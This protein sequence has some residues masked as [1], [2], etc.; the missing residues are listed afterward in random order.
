MFKFKRLSLVLAMAVLLVPL[1]LRAQQANAQASP[2]DTVIIGYTDGA[3][4]LDNADDYSTHGWEIL[5]NI[6]EG[7]LKYKPNSADVEPGLATDMPTM[8]SDGLTYTFTLHDNLQFADGTPLT[9]Q[10]VVDSVNRVMKLKGQVVGVVANY[11]DSVSA[12][13]AKTV[14]FKLQRPVGFFTSLVA[15]P[16]YY[17]VNPK[18]YPAD[19]FTKD[20]SRIDGD[21][22]YM[23]TSYTPKDQA[24]LQANPN[25]HGAQPL[26]KNIILRYFA[27][28]LQLGDAVETG[29]IDIAW[30]VLDTPDVLRLKNTAGISVYTV[31]GGGSLRYLV[32]NHQLK[33]FDNVQVRQA[34]AYLIDRNEIIDRAYQGQVKALYSMIPPGFL[35]ATDV[36]KTVY[37]SPQISK[38][39][40]LLNQAG[41]TT[42]KPLTIDLWWPLQHY[43]PD[44]ATVIKGQLEK[45][46]IIKVTTQAVEWSSYTAG[47]GKG[48][49]GFFVLGWFPSYTDPDDVTTAWGD[50]ANNTKLGVNYKNDQ[51]DK[52]LNEGRTTSDPT[53]RA[54]IYKQVQDLWAQDVVTIPLL[55][56]GEHTVYRTGAVIGADQIGSTLTLFYSVLQ[57]PANGAPPLPTSAATSAATAAVTAAPT[58]AVPTAAA[59]SAS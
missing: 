41:Y 4:D 31:P 34:I 16:P 36:F 12:P 40:A 9:A 54:A 45:S 7:L 53:Q 22:P 29:Q 21:G 28:S 33:P 10:T 30:R 2:S 6:G 11:V 55:L 46:G 38:A 15:L 42:D 8:S 5:Q 23:L 37:D 43:G 26:T 59:T 44:I 17:P 32:F 1:G 14:V 57:K 50:S 3:T 24:V 56:V 27:N 48:D 58:T 51:M 49:Y 35:G 39:V 47:F 19:S 52:L 20:P 18:I 13:D 25:Y